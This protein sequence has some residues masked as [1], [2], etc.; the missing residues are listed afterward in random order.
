LDK[1]VNFLRLNNEKQRQCPW[2][3]T[4]FVAE[5]KKSEVYNWLYEMCCYL[6]HLDFI[7]AILQ[8]LMVTVSSFLSVSITAVSEAE[9][10]IAAEKLPCRHRHLFSEETAKVN[11]IK[12]RIRI[13]KTRVCHFRR[14]FK[15]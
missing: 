15:I 9:V 11:I 3:A 4:L 13:K 2:H 7:I 14:K 5:E 8:A 12:N 1:S 10:S 6:K